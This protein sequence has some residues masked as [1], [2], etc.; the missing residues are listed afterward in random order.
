MT[1]GI[2]ETTELLVF[3]RDALHA[4]KS[5]L[6]DGRIGLGD[7]PLVWDLRDK[8]TAAFTGLQGLAA[9]AADYDSGELKVVLGLVAE[10]GV[11]AWG[12]VAPKAA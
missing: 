11:E 4:L 8:A 3:A 12:F 10:V 2:K 1:V 7:L 6:K 5:A 9:E